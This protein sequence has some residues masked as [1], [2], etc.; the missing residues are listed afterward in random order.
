MCTLCTLFVSSQNLVV[1]PDA[2]SLPKGTG[3]TIVSAGGTTCSTA[4]T[5]SYNNWTMVPDGNAALYP[6]D[7][8][9][10]IAGGTSFFSGCSVANQGPFELK[11]DI[12]VTS[13]AANIDLGK[14]QYT[15]SGFI[16]T[17]VSGETDQGSFIVDYLDA[18][19][20]VLGTSYTSGPQSNALGSLDTWNEYTSTRKAP[21]GTRKISVRLQTQIFNNTPEINVYFDDIS[22]AKGIIIL[23]V[24][25]VSFTGSADGSNVNI[26]WKT[27]EELNLLNYQLQRSTNGNGFTTIATITA[28]RSDYSYTDKNIRGNSDKYFYRL[29][30][31]DIDGK[32]SYSNVLLVKTKL[33]Q[34]LRL[35]PNPAKGFVTVSGLAQ[36]GIITI[37]NTSGKLV[38]SSPSRT[39]TASLNISKLSSGL[40]YV[41]FSDGKNISHQKLVVE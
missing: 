3:W 12:N 22:L 28:G 18:S 34:A 35:S 21:V 11:Q 9:T 39:N 27:E 15:F 29:K 23:P 38:L 17:P 40:Y 31:V 25:L 30:M 13:D 33:Q 19:N 36:P 24:T 8:T 32:Y 14:I 6:F 41:R 26:N 7:H 20:V 4:P 1:N 2:E 37:F 10:G 5:N 16:Q